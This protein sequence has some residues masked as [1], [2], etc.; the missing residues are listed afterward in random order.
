ML[1]KINDPAARRAPVL[2][3][4]RQDIFLC[5]REKRMTMFTK[6][7]VMSASLDA[8]FAGGIPVSVSEWS[9]F[10]SRRDIGLSWFF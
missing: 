10:H 4:L 5:R 9:V 6:E 3:R 7:N 2:P 8:V 1:P